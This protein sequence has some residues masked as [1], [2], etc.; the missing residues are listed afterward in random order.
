MTAAR[1]EVSD[2]QR[3]VHRAGPGWQSAKFLDHRH[4]ETKLVLPGEGPCLGFPR[5]RTRNEVHVFPDDIFSFFFFTPLFRRR[6]L[7][8]R[9]HEDDVKT[10]QVIEKTE[11]SDGGDELGRLSSDRTSLFLSICLPKCSSS[12]SILTSIQ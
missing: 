2:P 1:S 5:E 9:L 8:P 7:R 11:K 3:A 12:L 4:P 10:I 6:G